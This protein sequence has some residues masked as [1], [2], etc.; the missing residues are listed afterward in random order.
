MSV[1]PHPISGFVLAGGK[2]S[3]MGSD[4][5]ELSLDGRTLLEHALSTVRA[6]CG[7]ALIIGS[8]ARYSSF[9]FGYE[10]IFPD[11][12]PLSGVHSALTHSQT[13]WNLIIAV[14]TPFLKPELLRYL[15]ERAS[16]VAHTV[17]APKISGIVQP[18]CA[19]YSR[20]FLPIAEAALKAGKYKLEPLFPRD[21]TLVVTEE[22]LKQFAFTAEMFENLNT[23]EDMERARRRFSGVD[24]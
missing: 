13:E 24:T 22:E 12:G 6:V 7:D 20:K 4:K 19:V 2:S 16:A 18:L 11:C 1:P 3:R 21:N 9:G 10:D 15:I 14:D 5:A 8:R 23:P 17:V